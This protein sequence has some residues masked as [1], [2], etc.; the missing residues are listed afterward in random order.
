MSQVTTSQ[1]P[2]GSGLS[3]REAINAVLA[4]LMSNNSGPTEPA[5]PIP[6][7]FWGDTATNDLKIRNAANTAWILLSDMIGALEYDRPMSLNVDQ[8]AQLQ[9]NAGLGEVSVENI[10]PI[11]KGGTGATSVD[12]A[13]AALN[14]AIIPP[15]VTFA[16]GTGDRYL[17]AGGTW[18]WIR[19]VTNTSGG[20]QPTS[21]GAGV[22][23]GGTL[24]ASVGAN[25]YQ[26][27]Y[28]RV[29]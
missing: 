27:F 22:A 23:A 10:L 4:A 13:R 18:A 28:W 29:Q 17:P 11:S 20:P 21:Y 8:Q 9:S 14:A 6:F 26:C 19:L 5:N 1:V 7:Q 12:V 3:V 16:G 24:I 25:S 2:S 15:T